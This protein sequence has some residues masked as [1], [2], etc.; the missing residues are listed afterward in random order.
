M[1][2]LLQVRRLRVDVGSGRHRRPVVHGV[3]LG[4]QAGECVGIVGESGSGKSLTM[5]AVIGLLPLGARLTGGTLRFATDGE[6]TP[7]EPEEI[8]GH[9]IAMV[10]QEPMTA[11]N[12]TRRAGDLV[13]DGVLSAR[14]SRISRR[15][16][17]EVA[18]ELMGEVGIPDPRRRAT[19]YPHELSGGLRQRVMIAMALAGNP[20]LLLCDEPTTALDVT[21]Q[22]QILGLL[23]GLRRDRGLALL[24]VTH[25]LGVVA[26]IAQRLLVMK[27]GRIVEEGPTAEVLARPRHPYTVALRSGAAAIEGR[28]ATEVG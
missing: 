15:R 3:D 10:F 21:V 17:R 2:D 12:P 27:D 25:D 13:A 19:A 1:T 5:R 7:Y 11:L 18:V 28:R 20:R 16:A 8:R 6:L 4:V 9:G 23:D 24:F 22:D 14:A 26:Q